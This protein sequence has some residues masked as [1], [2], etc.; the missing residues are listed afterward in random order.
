M[1]V[2]VA[3]WTLD[4][5][6]RAIAAGI[7]DGCPVELLNGLIV[8][9]AS[10]GPRH[11]NRSARLHAHF[12]FASRGRYTVRGGHPITLPSSSSEPEPVLA[13]VRDRD[14]DSEHPQPDDIF[15]VIEFAQSSLAKDI[16]V[17]RL[18]Y[19]I[20][21]IQ[22]YWVVNLKDNCVLVY[23]QPRGGDYQ[24]QEKICVGQLAP[25]AFPDAAVSPEQIL[26][27]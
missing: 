18:V 16:K 19:A 17:K 13:L 9:I 20:A 3:R 7:F 5:Y 11:S 14:Y 22:E 27:T 15:L 10:E 6:H 21:G 23:R 4:R 8:D 24:S 12:L 2:T 26:G 1:A 25:L